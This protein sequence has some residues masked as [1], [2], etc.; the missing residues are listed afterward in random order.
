[1]TRSKTFA[2]SLFFLGAGMPAA[3][4]HS[5]HH[6][7]EAQ[8]APR[9]GCE[10]RLP[11]PSCGKTPTPAIDAEGRLWLAW[12]QKGRVYAAASADLG[13]S[14]G[15]AVAINERSESI[16][17]NGDG[18]PK[19]VLGRQGEIHVTYTE[20]LEKPFTGHIRYS[21]SEDGGKS[22]GPPIIINDNRD[23]IS[24]R[25]DSIAAAP[26]GRVTIVWI[27]KR[28]QAKAAHEKRPYPGAA[29]YVAVSED[30]GRSFGANRKIADT[31]CECCRIG[32]AYDLDGL[33][34]TLW[35]HVYGTDTR[36][37][38]LTKFTSRDQAGEIR[39]VSHDDWHINA[40]PHHGPSLAIDSKGTYHMSW[41]DNGDTGKGV[42]YAASRDQGRNVAPT[43]PVGNPMRQAGHPSLLA[44]KDHI[45]LAWIE[46]DG[47]RTHVNRMT[48]ADGGVSWSS[49]IHVAEGGAEADHPL[50]IEVKG[51]PYLSWLSV[52]EG[53]RLIPLESA[54]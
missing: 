27:D 25:F 44:I 51:K 1:M 49:P 13:K 22:F 3:A 38:A 36:D 39:R 32:L 11:S 9:P 15:P 20:R 16:D 42:F 21:R 30:G 52:P 26:D 8:N 4:Q 24:H 12:E 28:D 40:C 14:F 34:V 2:L 46:F 43:M 6:Q 29:L 18:R 45:H 41:F 7:H 31:S 17:N 23:I 47:S 5:G 19:I 50:L 33:P 37:H 54:P 35:R 10:S 48:S 53:Y